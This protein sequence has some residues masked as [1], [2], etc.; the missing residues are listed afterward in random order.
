MAR[1]R[2]IADTSAVVGL[3]RRRDQWHPW[4]SSEVV[5]LEPPFLTCE[6]VISE[7]CFL[8]QDAPGGGEKVLDLLSDGFLKISFSLDHEL[9]SIHGLIRKYDDVPMSLA[10]ACLVRMSELI[11]KSVIFTV[12]SDFLIYRRSGRRKIP[13]ISPY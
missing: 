8:L 2:I 12:D 13:L 4:V 6:A 3:I 1:N 5:G 7:S 11:D 9:A 10:D